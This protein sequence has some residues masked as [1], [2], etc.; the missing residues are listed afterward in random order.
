MEYFNNE[1]K[2]LNTSFI[3]QKEK[4]EAELENF[5][6][7]YKIDTLIDKIDQGRVPEILEFYFGG[8]NQKNL[9]KIEEFSPNAETLNFIDF[10]Q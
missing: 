2:I 4:N 9:N 5:K 7:E 10:K 1:D 6:R 3:L 8:D